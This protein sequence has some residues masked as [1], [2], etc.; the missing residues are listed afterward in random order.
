MTTAVAVRPMLLIAELDILAVTPKIE[1]QADGT[2]ALNDISLSNTS[3]NRTLTMSGT[4][5]TVVSGVVSDGASAISNLTNRRQE[6]DLG[7]ALPASQ[8]RLFRL[9]GKIVFNGTADELK[10]RAGDDRLERAIAHLMTEPP[11]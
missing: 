3:T 11:S 8:R 9:D 5:D 10:Q 7:T 6:I 1:Q 4:S 2:V